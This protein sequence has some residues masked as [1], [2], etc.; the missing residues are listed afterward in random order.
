[1]MNSPIR[2]LSIILRPGGGHTATEP[3]E[4]AGRMKR[5]EQGEKG[6]REGVVGWLS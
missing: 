2:P 4:G 1:M 3:S 6:E 5:G